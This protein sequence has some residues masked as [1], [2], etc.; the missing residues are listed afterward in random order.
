[1]RRKGLPPISEV[2]RD[3]EAKRSKFFFILILSVF[4]QPFFSSSAHSLQTLSQEQIGAI[5]EST[6]KAVGMGQV[7]GAV[8]LIGNRE[9]ILYR[10]ALGHRSIKPKKLP[11]TMDTLFDVASLTKVI[12]TTTAL[13]QLVESGKLGLEDPVT[14]YFPEFKA[15]GKEQITVRHLL[16]HY[17]GLKAGLSLQPDWSGYE[18]GLKGIAEEKPIV[19][20]GTLFI[21]SDINFQI[22]GEMIRRISGQSLDQYCGEHI[23]R[24]LGMKD[25]FFNP[26]ADLYDRIAP[27]QW[28]RATGHMRPGKVHD[29][30][31]SRMGGV[32][33]HA[34]LFS[35]ADDL[36]IF[37]RMI[38]NGGS[39]Q[40]VKIL[41]PSTVEK[42]TGPESPA[43]RIPL[44]G[45]GWEIDG[46]FASNRDELFPVGSFAHTGFTGTGIWIDPISETYVILLTSRLHP[47]GK[48]NAEPLRSQIL[49]LVSGAVGQISP[50]QVLAKRPSLQNH[51]GEDSQR[52][53]K[54]GLEVL[55][56]RKFS[57]L[58]GLRVGLITN[59]SGIDSGGRRSVDLIRRAPGVKLTKIF[60]PEH[61]LTGREDTKVRHARDPSTG[62]PVYSLYGNVLQP[63]KKMLDGLDVLVFDIQ[64]AGVR[65]YTYI[66]TLGYAME[67]AA[68]KGIAFCVLD[69]PNPITSS[70]VQGPMMDKN[71]KSFTGYFPLPIRHGMTVGELAQMFNVE[72]K[73]RVK[74]HII[75]MAGYQRTCWYDET[76]LPW[77]NPSPNLRTLTQAILYPGVALVEGANVSV[78]RGT[79]SP[80]ELVGSPWI[81]ADEFTHYLNRRQIPGVEFKPTHF[82]PYN[83]RFKGQGCHG[84][85]IIL[86][87][88][89]ALDSPFLGIEIASAL[90]RLYPKDFQIEKML[91]L[92]GARWLLDALKESD[93]HAIVAKWQ[94]PLEEFCK[95]RAKYLIY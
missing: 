22:L 3:N 17:S 23:F 37:A 16:T 41:E 60:S 81:D 18:E 79:V 82:V 72:N 50:E 88:R 71:M 62:L 44:R 38:L 39:L 57:P 36:S 7:P 59:H 5:E 14:K 93:P 87:D 48:G 69:R 40:D 55:V 75:K 86:A 9:K 31:A 78:G 20:P 56:E 68:K 74:L 70:R 84:V 12:A 30:V 6:K 29:G 11:M 73:I 89:Q 19:P 24:P 80:F 8:I 43:G 4:I 90:Y 2:K 26:P 33:G 13:M 46:P 51:Y 1:M 34:G 94:D 47:F 27:T 53:V 28:D 42:M 32:V 91:P 10:R 65:F 83:N 63:S 76:G 61:G 92:I 54:T 66:T 45:L 21:Y 25:T 85:Q 77:T 95:L 64:D 49:S 52:K 58:T 15:N 67:A 35:T